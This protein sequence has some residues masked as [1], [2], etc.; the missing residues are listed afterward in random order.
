MTRRSISLPFLTLS[1]LISLSACLLVSCSSKS[2]SNTLVY[3]HI[4]EAL[5]LDPVYP[6]DAVS[7]GLIMNIYETLIR[8]KGSSLDKF[9]PV[10]ATKVPT[11]ENGLI[12][13]DGLTYRFPIRK[14]VKFHNG[15]ELTPED[16]RYSLLRFILTDP[17]GGPTA[18]LLEPILGLTST[19]NDKNKII[20]DFKEAEK[21]IRV[22]GDYVVIRLKRPFMPFLSIMARWSYVMDK[23]WCAKHGEWTGGEEDWK[24]FN[25]KD[26]H[27]SFLFDH[28]NGT[29]PFELG[30]WD[31]NKKIV[32][33]KR[34]D[35]YWATPAKLQSIV[36]KT[37][38]EFGTRRLML[39]SGD[40][41]IIDIPRTFEPQLRNVE[42]VV[43][44]DNLRRLKTDPTLY[45]TLKIN[46]VGN[47]DIGSGKLD[48]NGI[49]SDFFTDRDL[50]KAFSYS[51]DYTAFL[52]ESA[53][54]KATRAIGPVPPGLLGYSASLPKYTFDLK[55]AELYFKKAWKGKVWERGFKF[56]ITYNSGSQL[57]QAACEVFKK[58]VE[59]VNPKFH[60]NVRGL[61]WP[62]YFDKIQSRKMPMFSIG[63]TGDYPDPHNFVFPYFHS[64]G[65]YA[66]SQGY[67]NPQM[68]ELIQQAVATLN[69]KERVRLYHKI[70]DLGHE[71][72]I[73][74]YTIHPEHVY[75]MRKEVKGFVDNAVFMGV[76]FY[77]LSK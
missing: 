65:K 15:A 31:R 59:Q 25:D 50:R 12:S 21:A 47:P 41:D 29:G 58:G 32:Y 66:K 30:H 23:E 45:F 26:M 9:E 27:L 74:I 10:L 55:K 64:H 39:E 5:S 70:H 2:K 67:S 19:R 36:M 43:L 63:W 18:L 77:P 72:A 28:T 24:E 35:Q 53:R 38:D 17:S 34:F 4:G 54:G 42:G 20:V 11:V 37:V 49:P 52:E 57:R 62:S 48:G 44:K 1:A 6:Y 68:D 33:L 60:V 13:K 51:F 7:Q 22:D 56:T 14:G 71:E 40:A 69:E 8:F 3:T 16:V 73:Q 75:A 76:W 46:S 61:D